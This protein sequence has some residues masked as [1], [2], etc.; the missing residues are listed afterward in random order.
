MAVHDQL[1]E[2]APMGVAEDGRLR[3][4]VTWAYQP[5]QLAI[6]TVPCNVPSPEMFADIIAHAQL[7]ELDWKPTPP[8]R[9]Q[10]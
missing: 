3:Y 8:P 4:G 7:A 10:D 6:V 5:G 1:L 9:R 2:L